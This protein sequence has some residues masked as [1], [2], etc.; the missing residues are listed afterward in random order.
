MFIIKCTVIVQVPAVPITASWWFQLPKAIQNF[1]KQLQLA[2]RR[3]RCVLWRLKRCNCEQLPLDGKRRPG[4]KV[5]SVRDLSSITALAFL[6]LFYLIC[7][8]FRALQKDSLSPGSKSDKHEAGY[9]M[10]WGRCY[11]MQLWEPACLP[12][13]INQHC[14]PQLLNYCHECLQ[15][16]CFNIL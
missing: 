2:W 10:L 12:E 1:P 5:A 13:Q 4:V 11:I 6:I 9:H 7:H 3:G 14:D 8:H 16:I 15:K